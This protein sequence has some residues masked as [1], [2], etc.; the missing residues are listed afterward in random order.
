MSSDKTPNLNI[1]RFFKHSSIYAIGN[2]ANRVGSFLLLPLYTHYLSV[3]KYGAL[4]LFYVTSSIISSVLSVGMAH[5]TLRFYFE[6]DS[7][8][9]RNK[10][11]TTCLMSSAL[12][13]IPVVLL[14]S[15]FNTSLANFIFGDPHYANTFNLVYAILVLELMRQIGLAYFR[16]KE[17]STLYVIVCLFQLVLQVGCNVYTVGIRHMEVPG[18]LVG[19]LLSVFTGW[20][21][22]M[23]VVI[24]ECQFSFD[25]SKMR[26]I[27]KY[28]YPFIFTVMTG[29]ILRNSDRIILRAFF[30]LREVGIYALAFKFGTLMQELFLDPFNLSFGAF[31]FSIMN[32]KDVKEKLVKIYNYLI[33]GLFFAGLG[34]SLYSREVLRF[35]TDP[36]YWEAS[37]LIPL[38]VLSFAAAGSG[39]TFQTGIYYTKQTKYMIYI[40][41]VSDTTTI[42]LYMILVP[43][44]GVFGAAAAVICKGFIEAS[45]TYSVSTRLYYVPYQIFK[46]VKIMAIAIVLVAIAQFTPADSPFLSLFLKTGLLLTFPCILY[47]AGFLS[48]EDVERAKEFILATYEKLRLQLRPAGQQQ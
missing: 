25:L 7:L 45:L 44:Y 36:S 27:L 19:N 24:K 46:A 47:L 30:S 23:C 14:L 37:K 34:I 8:K 9:E 48:K 39:Y 13:S 4:E 40:N 43:R 1:G 5:A 17:Y 22:I 31:R 42:L 20:L 11:V 16:A 32:E 6:Y 10:V 15:R 35:L 2:I 38:I 28:T 33:M 41:S 18:V 12:F 3:D 26:A 21:I 29:I